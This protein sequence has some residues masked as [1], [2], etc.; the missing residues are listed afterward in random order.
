MPIA[1]Q[2][3]AQDTHGMT[4]GCFLS[5]LH[6]LS[7]RSMAGKWMSAI[8]SSL[9]DA[10]II[11]LGGDIFDF[12]WAN[13]GG[14]QETLIAA[15]DW[16]VQ[17]MATYPRARFV[18]LLGNHDSHPDMQL[19]LDDLRDSSDRFEW[20]SET[21]QLDDCLFCH[22]DVLDAGSSALL[23]RYR[24]RFHH[25]RPA[26]RAAHG[27]YDV[28]VAMRLHR[29]LPRLFHRPRATCTRLCELLE[30]DPY[31]NEQPIARIFFGHTHVPIYDLPLGSIHF[32]NP[33]AA[34][35]HM[36]FA[37]IHFELD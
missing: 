8:E 15:K 23:D 4:I 34:L 28:A 35:K 18:Y 20:H 2:V 14:H 22:G 3:A 1:W 27:A 12:R 17:H 5:D 36:S 26:S 6:L 32:F 30:I 33:G 31:Q 25:E 37:P 24:R 21:Y 13:L 7:P 10:E 29:T 19:L 11:I 9:R 16:L